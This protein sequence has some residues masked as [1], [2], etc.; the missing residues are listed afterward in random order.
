MTGV[1]I[2]PRTE[3]PHG[4]M[5]R[6][7]F[8]DEW[9]PVT[10]GFNGFENVRVIKTGRYKSGRDRLMTI[11]RRY[12]K[13]TKTYTTKARDGMVIYDIND[14][15]DKLWTMK[16][17]KLSQFALAWTNELEAKYNIAQTAEAL[18]DNA[19]IIED[20]KTKSGLNRYIWKF[21]GA[22]RRAFRGKDRELYVSQ[23]EHTE[24]KKKKETAPSFD[25]ASLLEGLSDMNEQKG[26]PN[27]LLADLAE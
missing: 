21:G 3:R 7:N 10:D 24:R 26:N 27:A 22:T 9:E 23:N 12:C 6:K 11:G 13:F 17:P 5:S 19:E 15:K 1:Y 25:T 8:T 4:N 14:S 2:I 20:G 18:D 16:A